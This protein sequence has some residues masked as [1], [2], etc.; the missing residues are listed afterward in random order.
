MRHIGKT[1]ARQGIVTVCIN[2]R[3]SPGVRHPE[4]VRDVALAFDWVKRNVDHYGGDPEDVFI[5]G[6]SA[7]GHLVAL[8]ALNE[9]Y[10]AELGRTPD[11]IVGVIAIS[12]VYQVGGTSFIFRGFDADEETLIDASPQFHVHEQQPPFLIIYA[13]NDLPLLDIQ[14]I[15]LARELEKYQSPVRLL[16][17]EDR[18]HLTIFTDIGE[19]DDPTTEAMLEFIGEYSGALRPGARERRNVLGQSHFP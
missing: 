13:Q 19:R 1:F 3:L 11:E 9:R 8:L 14:A 6:H 16:R 17:V 7:G 4:H 12:G 2:Y 15:S 18:G 10:L 5:A